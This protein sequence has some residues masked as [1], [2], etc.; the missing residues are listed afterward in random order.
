[1]AAQGIYFG[2][3]SWKYRGWEGTI[4][5]GGYASEAQFQRV[6]LREYTSYFPAVGV[7]FTYYAWPMADMMSYL[8]DSTP[9]NF[10]MCP[11]VT[12][13]ITLS[14]FPDIPTYGKWAGQKNPDYLNPALFEEQFLQP[15]RRLKDRLGVILFEF[16]GP[17]ENELEAFTRFFEM[18]PRD[19]AYA[20]EFRNPALVNASFYERLR[21]LGLSPAFS[22]WTRLPPIS[23]QWNAYMEAGGAKDTVPLVGL[24]LLRPGMS[25]EEAV[26]VY[27]PYKETK[28]AYLPGRRDLADLA[29]FARSNNRKAYILVTNRLEGSAPY[30]VGGVLN[31]LS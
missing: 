28:E 2:T 10:R 24:G 17:D 18:V 15:I 3:S 31:A 30:T 14:A 8:L 27:Q 7:E 13:R 19:C 22:A 5:R 23:E 20:V 11:K 29:N 25:Y 26:R 4:Y 12:K 16:S 9:E 1:L 6:S 21:S